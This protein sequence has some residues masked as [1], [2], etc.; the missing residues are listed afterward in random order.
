MRIG[1]LLTVFAAMQPVLAAAQVPAKIGYQGRIL[2]PD[3]TP[4]SGTAGMT[5][6]LFAD[7][8]PA[9]LWTESQT[10]ALTDGYYATSLGAATA[11]DPSLFD[12]RE[13]FLEVGIN[14]HAFAPR[15]R[16]D[17][18]PYCLL[19]GNAKNVVGGAINASSISLNGVQVISAAP[20]ASG[21]GLVTA[22]GVEV[23]GGQTSFST[24]L[25]KGDLFTIGPQT[26]VVQSIT[27][28]TSL[29]VD[30][31]FNPF[32]TAPSTFT[33]QRAPLRIGS[34]GHPK[35]VVTASGRLQDATGYLAPVGAVMMYLGPTPPPGWLLAD[36][37]SV[38]R[39][40]YPELF[41]AIGTTYGAADSSSF[42]LPDFR[43]VFP[44]GAG[45]TGRTKGVDAAG[46]HYSGTLGAYSQDRFQGHHHTAPT[47][48]GTS[49][50]PYN[51]PQVGTNPQGPSTIYAQT[52]ASDGV[53]GEPRYGATTE[54][55]S[56]SVNFIVKY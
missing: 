51:V 1:M 49:G 37:S 43:G 18:V 14:G 29:T 45:T 11:F 36:G 52:P 24:H 23:T 4:M 54:P 56:L 25:Q 6:S 17:S 13:L 41:A 3:G 50:S 27:S 2:N 7:G 42:N 33:Y 26:R 28:D 46:N 35:A 53:N 47:L 19:A 31:S 8:S 39:L 10:L 5:F 20:A 55:Q 30:A 32:V 34:D 22:S 21:V 44:K 48:S 15:Q 12:G 40:T 9:A 16:V 38:P